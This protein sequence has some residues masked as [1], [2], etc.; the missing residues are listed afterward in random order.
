MHRRHSPCPPKGIGLPRRQS[1]REPGCSWQWFPR[2]GSYLPAPHGN[3]WPGAVCCSAPLSAAYRLVA[4]MGPSSIG[5]ELDVAGVNHPP[6]EVRLINEGIKKVFPYPTVPPAAEATMVILPV[7]QVRRQVSPEPA[8]YLIRGAPVRRFQNTAFR[9]NRLAVLGGPVLLPWPARQMRLKKFP[10][11]V[12]NI[13]ASMRCCHI[14][15]PHLHSRNSD[16]PLCYDF[17]DIPGP[18]DFLQWPLHRSQGLSTFS[19]QR[20]RK[21]SSK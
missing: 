13:V 19:R 12:G 18:R 21:C 8:P 3:P 5:V 4:T 20:W 10:N 6:L 11:S 2:S 17:D 15:T 14:P 7:S 16:L 1:D 9:N